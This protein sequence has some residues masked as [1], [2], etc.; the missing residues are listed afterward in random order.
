MRLHREIFGLG[1][2]VLSTLTAPAAEKKYDIGATDAVIKIGN[3]AAYSGPAS[4]Y[5]AFAKAEQAY[6]QKINDEGGILGRTIKYI[7]YD[8]AASPPKTIEQARK[9]V[10]SDEVLAVLSSMGTPTNTA[11]HRYLNN[12]K[13]PQIFVGSGA[14]KW[15]NPKDF[16]WT[17]G[18]S[19]SYQAEGRIYAAYLLKERP[20]A[21]IGI[22]YENDD[23]GKDYLKGLRD[24]LGAAA[25]TMIAAEVTY[26]ITQPTLDS[27]IVQLKAANIDTLYS[28]TTAK[29]TSQVIRKL[30]DLA[31]KPLVIIPSV[32]SSV[33]AALEPAG[34][35]N[36]KDIVSSIFQKD[37]TDPQWK[38]D[39]ETQE[40]L[41]FMDKYYPGGSKADGLYVSGYVAAQMMAQVLRQCGDDLTRA[42]VMKQ[43]ASLQGFRAAMLLPDITVN[44][45]PTDFRPIKEM[46]LMR[47]NGKTWERFGS[48]TRGEA[49]AQ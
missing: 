11:I 29:F 7:S 8:D 14:A 36:S 2:L 42:N 40:Y 1:L 22:L 5:S 26:D 39:A 38:D 41:A 6:F 9:L 35:E 18:F 46:Q 21:K 24:G 32:S 25:K 49:S 27:Q 43:A 15:D 17:M 31:W 20:A 3:I 19:P 13:V 12:Q 45:S 34:L 4:P 23:F 44:T 16:P 30:T 33:S 48:L 28:V 10:E 47:F 37:P